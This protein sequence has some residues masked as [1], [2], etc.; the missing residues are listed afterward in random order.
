MNAA[1]SGSV[2]AEMDDIVQFS[3][4]ALV[5][6]RTAPMLYVIDAQA[7][8]LFAPAAV[9]SEFSVGLEDALRSIAASLPT[10]SNPSP[11]M[12]KGCL[13]RTERLIASAGGEVYAVFFERV[14]ISKNPDGLCALPASDAEQPAG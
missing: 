6:S 9:E 8:V 12:F 10:A 4:D 13:V 14:A 1:E 3:A 7:N 11:R 2:V 5:Q